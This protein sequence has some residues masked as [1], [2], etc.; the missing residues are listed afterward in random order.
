M[1]FTR[2]YRLLTN[3]F[4]HYFIILHFIDLSI[5]SFACISCV[6]Q[7]SQGL[8]IGTSLYGYVVEAQPSPAPAMYMPVSVQLVDAAKNVFVVSTTH[9]TVSLCAF[10]LFLR[11]GSLFLRQG[12]ACVLC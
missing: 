5:L 2:M 1:A 8:D 3:S 6:A 9:A 12:S 7:N 11:Q 10:S 4:H